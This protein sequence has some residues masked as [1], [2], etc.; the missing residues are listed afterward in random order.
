MKVKIVKSIEALWRYLPSGISTY[1]I[2]RCDLFRKNKSF[3]FV[4]VVGLDCISVL[5]LAQRLYMSHCIYWLRL[6]S[7]GVPLMHHENDTA[8]LMT[9]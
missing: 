3:V 9:L 8:A 4:D 1:S 7:Y 6:E 5:N 2:I